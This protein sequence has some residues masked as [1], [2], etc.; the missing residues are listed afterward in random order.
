MYWSQTVGVS[1]LQTSGITQTSCCVLIALLPSVHA[2]QGVFFCQWFFLQVA[3]TSR[4][5]SWNSRTICTINTSRHVL[6]TSFT[7]LILVV[8]IDL[9]MIR[10]PKAPVLLRTG[11]TQQAN[12]RH[13]PQTQAHPCV[14]DQSRSF[15]TIPKREILLSSIYPK[16]M[17]A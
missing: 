14:N 2:S 1:I 6:R 10:L 12:R 9:C 17:K 13:D 11:C 5:Q 7:T 4:Y 3:S 16:I 15:F 8:K